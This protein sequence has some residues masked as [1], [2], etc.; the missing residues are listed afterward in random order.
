MV[1]LRA[2]IPLVTHRRSPA[3]THLPGSLRA[4][5]LMVP[6][7]RLGHALSRHYTFA[8]LLVSYIAATMAPPP[9]I[10]VPVNPTRVSVIPAIV[11]KGGIVITDVAIAAVAVS[12]HS[13]KLQAAQALLV[14]WQQ[15]V[16]VQAQV[17]V[18]IMAVAL[19]LMPAANAVVRPY[20]ALNAQALLAVILEVVRPILAA[21]A[22]IQ[23]KMPAA[24]AVRTDQNANA[25]DLLL[26]APIQIALLT[27]DAGAVIQGKMSA[28]IAVR[29]DQNANAED[30]L[31]AA[32]IQ[33]ALLTLDAGA[34]AVLVALFA[35]TIVAARRMIVLPYAPITEVDGIMLKLEVVVQKVWMMVVVATANVIAT[36]VRKTDLHV[37]NA[38]WR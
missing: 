34:E 15:I 28:A 1:G 30:L 38:S 25:E 9:I 37:H 22:V 6:L 33:I 23:G 27:L 11:F 7:Q 32:P 18:A 29:T 4:P 14:Q 19:L 36:S 26:V 3:T 8:T 13:L 35:T 31:P 10:R 24:I 2:C 5:Y 12:L 16:L 20:Y 17:L 21:D